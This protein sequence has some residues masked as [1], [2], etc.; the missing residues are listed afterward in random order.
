MSVRTP[1]LTL[2]ALR[3]GIGVAS[4]CAPTLAA[5]VAGYPAEHENPTARMMGRLFGVREV[6]LAAMVV[7]A[8]VRPGGASPGV[9]VVQ[10]AVDAADVAVQ[11]WP[12]WKREGIDRGA[13]GGI[14]LAATAAVLWLRLAHEAW[15]G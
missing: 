15:R 6:L 10:A 5:K 8:I 9:F 7:N 3:A 1:A 14:A 2:S 12:V 4:I 13:V 11:S